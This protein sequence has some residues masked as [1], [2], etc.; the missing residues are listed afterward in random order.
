MG[1]LIF[2]EPKITPREA[3][4]QAKQARN[5]S[6]FGGKGRLGIPHRLPGSTVDNVLDAIALE[7]ISGLG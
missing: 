6:F 3:P 4:A 5:P 7:D 1:G 2:S